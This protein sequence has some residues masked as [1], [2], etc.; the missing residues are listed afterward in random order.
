MEGYLVFAWRYPDKD[1]TRWL[2]NN[3]GLKNALRLENG[4]P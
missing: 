1:P 3:A 4:V 2:A